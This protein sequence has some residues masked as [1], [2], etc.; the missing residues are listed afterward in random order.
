M[1]NSKDEIVQYIKFGVLELPIHNRNIVEE[2]SDSLGYEKKIKS[3]NLVSNDEYGHINSKLASDGNYELS[4]KLLLDDDEIL[5]LFE[6]VSSHEISIRAKKK[7]SYYLY[8]SS[9]V[10]PP[11][12]SI[13]L[14]DNRLRDW[15]TGSYEKYR[16][17]IGSLEKF[18]VFK[19]SSIKNY[20]IVE[21]SAETLA[22]V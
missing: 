20:Y 6:I 11:V 17:N 15:Y 8:D 14:E 3:E 21:F 13:I 12:E 5:K 19:I 2:D 7:S 22:R 1:I 10:M 9:S 18:I 4:W 16:I